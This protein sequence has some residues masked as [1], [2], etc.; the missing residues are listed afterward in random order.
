MAQSLSAEFD[1]LGPG[2]YLQKNVATMHNSLSVDDQITSPDYVLLFTWVDAH[3]Q[4]ILKYVQGYSRLYPDARLIVLTTSL[5]DMLFPSSVAEQ[6]SHKAIFQVLQST[7][8]ASVLIHTFSN[9]GAYRVTQFFLAYWKRFQ[10]RFNA[11][12]MILDS[13]P[14]K[15][16]IRRTTAAVMY[17]LP[18]YWLVRLLGKYIVLAALILLRIV[19]KVFR[20]ENV[21]TVIRRRL[22]DPRIVD[23]QIPRCYLYSKADDMVWW[24]DVEEHAFEAKQKG[25]HVESVRFETSGHV[26]HPREDATKYWDAI[27]TMWKAGNKQC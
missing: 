13:N 10:L 5:K 9:G 12:A 18:K 26:N 22:N 15:G 3:A 17:S 14:G 4:H 25:W 23:V 1:C 24:Q 20:R 6:A 11:K 8:E 19:D 27:S 21:V 7:P 16:T 2:L